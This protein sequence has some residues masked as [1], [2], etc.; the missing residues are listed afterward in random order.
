MSDDRYT[1]TNMKAMLLLGGVL[2]LT[3]L[4]T[5]SR[6]EG[7]P[8]TVD[9]IRPAVV[10]IGTILPANRSPRLMGTGFVVADGH[11]VLT[12]AHV[13]EGA[14]DL[15]QREHYVVFI[16]RGAQAAAQPVEK[17]AIDE[18]HDLVLLS[19]GDRR[20]TPV[21]LGD[22]DRVREGEG[23][24]FTGFPIADVLGLYPAT[25]RALVSAITP[26][27]T[28]MASAGELGPDTI[29]RLRSQPYEVFQLDATAYPGNSGS[30]LFDPED[31]SVIGILNMV[32]VKE[33]REGPLAH[34]SGIA[35][36]IPIKYA[37]A[38]LKR[39]GL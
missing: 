17:V 23:Y 10:G 20:L 15:R 22:S 12:N 13:V 4:G 5:A 24:V 28:P 25:H 3:A 34:P 29:A 35:F 26:I 9:R 31:G 36:A 39:A 8:D 37:R 27:A 1:M 11:H 32:F 21:Q 38:L 33:T 19:I 6:A 30:P 7:L 16:G 18:E 14:L 2:A